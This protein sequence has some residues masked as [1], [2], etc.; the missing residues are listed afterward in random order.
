VRLPFG[1]AAAALRR[2][3]ALLLVFDDPRD[4]DLPALRALHPALERATAIEVP[5]AT[6]IQVPAADGLALRRQGNGWHLSSEAAPPAAFVLMRGDDGRLLVPT[7]RGGRVIVVPDPETGA[8]LFVGTVAS[9]TQAMVQPRHFV[10]FELLPTILGVALAPRQDEAVLRPVREGFAVPL[11]ASG[12]LNI[13]P[14]PSPAVAST[15]ALPRLLTLPDLPERALAARRLELFGAVATAPAQA[16][17]PWR[18]DLAETLLAL[19]LGRDA[20]AVAQ[21]AVQDDPLLAGQPRS[22]MLVGAAA[23]LAGRTEEALAALADRRL[24]DDGEPALWRVL[25]EPSA[26]GIATAVAAAPMILGYP[27]PLRRRVLPEL[28]ALL[29]E[30]GADGAAAAL[31]ED[32]DAAALPLARYA[33]GVLAERAGDAEAALAVYAELVQE[34]DRDARARAIGRAAD[35]RLATGRIDAAAAAEAM[36]AGIPAW[37][38]D[39]R[40]LARRLRAAALHLQASDPARAIAL[41]RET[42]PLFPDAAAAIAASMTDAVR[43]AATDPAVPPLTAVQFLADWVATRP[44]G[45]AV[46]A[47]ATRIADRLMQLELPAESARVLRLALPGSATPALLGIQLGEALL[48]A[49][50]PG[51]AVEVLRAVPVEGLT[52]DAA[53][54]RALALGAALRQGGNLVGADAVLREMGAPGA[55]ALADLLAA[56][57]DWGGAATAMRQHLDGFPPAPAPLSREARQALLRLGAFLALAGDEEGLA[58]LRRSHA[59]RMAGGPL[60]DAFVALVSGQPGAADLAR[61]RRDMAK[62]AAIE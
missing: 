7:E 23:T 21:L 6:A 4:V 56:R 26:A 51:A 14:L 35:L 61:L 45:A 2:A 41:L 9:G 43:M 53:Q 54:R 12:L 29:V 24:P 36:E 16:R 57:Q 47:V 50:D 60:G 44:D 46:D 18:L 15:L 1:G 8:L 22:L 25:A 5:G 31:L 58:G 48:A 37:R 62:L 27:A 19:G 34:R 10:G 17:G 42:E 13:G 33:R 39:G 40:E 11:A 49:G 38:G 30:A 20:L 28:A 59:D 52:A 32:A 55:A 3:G